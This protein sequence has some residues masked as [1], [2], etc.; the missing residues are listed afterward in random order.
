M[1]R[2]NF[3]IST[4]LLLGLSGCASSP[5]QAQDASTTPTETPRQPTPEATPRSTRTDQLIETSTPRPNDESDGD[6]GPE[7]EILSSEFLRDRT[8]TSTTS[9]FGSQGTDQPDPRYSATVG[10]TGGQPVGESQILVEVY[11]SDGEFIETLRSQIWRLNP[12]TR[13][14]VNMPVPREAAELNASTEIVSREPPGA[15]T[16]EITESSLKR[17]DD[18][19]RF[20]QHP[21]YIEGSGRNRSSEQIDITLYGQYLNSDGDVIAAQKGDKFD[22]PGNTAFSF[23]VSGFRPVENMDQTAEAVAVYP[24]LPVYE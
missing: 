13:W 6:L 7:L 24:Q 9:M 16:I 19:N 12:G 17:A 20:T 22:V 2:R 4:G 14:K 8:I 10:N 21:V 3:L 5:D 15:D 11:N 23:E 1:R 18:D